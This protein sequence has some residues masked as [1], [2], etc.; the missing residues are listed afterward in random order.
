MKVGNRNV[1]YDW[2]SK[3]NGIFK[4]YMWMTVRILNFKG[5]L[6]IGLSMVMNNSKFEDSLKIKCLRNVEGRNIEGLW[7][8]HFKGHFDIEI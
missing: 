8:Q 1:K 2:T 6:K 7:K 5:H 3:C 4:L